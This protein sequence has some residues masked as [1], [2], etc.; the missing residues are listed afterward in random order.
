MNYRNI[1]N[2]GSLILKNNSIVN[3]DIDA[4]LLLSISLN[5]SREKILLNLEE[6][7]NSRQI[8]QYVKLINRRKTKEPIS[9]IVGKKFFWKYEF[10]VNQYVLTPRFET[11]L[12]VEEVLKILKYRDNISVLDIGIGSGCILISLLKEKSMWKGTGIDISKLALKTAKT[13]A[14]IQQV[15]N[16]IKFVNS[17]IDKFLTSKYDL[18]VSNPPYINRADYNNLDLGVKGYEPKEALYGGIDGFR[19]IEKVIRKSKIILKNRGLLAM[20][21]GFGM[22]FKAKDMICKNGFYILKTIKDY[23]N[24]K[25]CIIAKKLDNETF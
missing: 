2:K 16:R 9:F 18:I 4:E 20:E 1:I 15:D 19:I 12:L 24:I 22:Y 13:N 5:K 23:Q 25:R 14:K 8:N 11:E 10:N 7:L 17:D 6:E 21:I 3:A